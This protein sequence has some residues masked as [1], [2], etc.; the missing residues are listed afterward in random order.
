MELDELPKAA[1]KL[2]EV[3]KPLAAALLP[4]KALKPAG[5]GDGPVAAAG[6]PV[7]MELR[8][9]AK[10][11]LLAAELSTPPLPS[12]KRSS[13]ALGDLAGAGAAVSFANKSRISDL[14]PAEDPLGSAMARNGFTALLVTETCF[15]CKQTDN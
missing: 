8:I 15:S 6:T 3:A 12:E 4:P 7:P 1:A 13:E 14:P 2:S 9:E 10:G 5:V 11:L